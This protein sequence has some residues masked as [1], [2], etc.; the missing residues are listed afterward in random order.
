MPIVRRYMTV[1][2]SRGKSDMTLQCP[3]IEELPRQGIIMDYNGLHVATRCLPPVF[4]KGMTN[5]IR[6]SALCSSTK[7]S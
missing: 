3:V 6:Y 5:I 1:S 2:A 4:R 7:V